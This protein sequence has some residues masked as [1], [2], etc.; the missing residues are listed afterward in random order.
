[1][2]AVSFL[3]C[4]YFTPGQSRLFQEAENRYYEFGEDW[5]KLLATTA[6][7]PD[8]VCRVG[9]VGDLANPAVLLP[10]LQ[11]PA[12]RELAS[13]STWYSSLYSP[14]LAEQARPEQLTALFRQLRSE[15][16]R[17]HSLRIAPM[18]P[19]SPEYRLTLMALRRAGWISFPFFAFWNWRLPTQG[20]RFN[21]YQ[22]SLP[23]HLRA[24]LKRKGP[25]FQ[26]PG[27]RLE[28][29]TGGNQLEQAI[30]DWTTIYHASWKN[31]EPFPEF[32][33][34]FIRM[35]ATKGWLRM[36]LA[37]IHD[38]PVAGQIWVIHQGRAA[39]YKLAQDQDYD[40]HSPGTVLTA[41]LLRHVMDVDHVS[42]VDY[43]IGDEE[44]KRDWMR[45]RHERWGLIA[46]NPGTLAGLLAAL[47]QALWQGVKRLLTRLG[48]QSGAPSDP[49]PHP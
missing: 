44:Y 9:Q 30:H 24:T 3:S 34:G 25:R 1:M 48:L 36:G 19:A 35:C 14:I 45:Q 11:R 22:R 46:Y 5:F 27:H 10:L 13:L 15:E 2:P 32:V 33:P 26:A 17:W 37:Y 41:H 21:E 49:A 40:R 39:I 18:D 12:K 43:L 28:I 23:G 47:R 38:R 4:D 20:A 29:I 16:P 7:A 6:L 31:P 42:E 8:E